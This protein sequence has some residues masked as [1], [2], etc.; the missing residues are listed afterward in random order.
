[1]HVWQYNV[2]FVLACPSL[3]IPMPISCVGAMQLKG[4]LMAWVAATA[5]GEG[6]ALPGFLR[7]K[8]AQV[9]VQV[10]KV[11]RSRQVF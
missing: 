2:V 10:V 3:Y 6:T 1:M 5:Q 11:S 8:L 4:T 9:I 7:N